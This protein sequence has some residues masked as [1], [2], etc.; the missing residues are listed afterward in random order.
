VDEFFAAISEDNSDFQVTCGT[1]ISLAN[2]LVFKTRP[3]L[4]EGCLDSIVFG[5]VS[6]PSTVLD[7]DT[8]R[9]W[10]TFCHFLI[11]R[12]FKIFLKLINELYFSIFIAFIIIFHVSK[13]Q[14]YK[15][16]II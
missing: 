3:F 8:P 6:S 15:I 14:F 5:C 16:Y 1:W 4:N 9:Q 7:V 10:R 11:M 12:T 2:D 13:N